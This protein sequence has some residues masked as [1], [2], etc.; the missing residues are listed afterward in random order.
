MPKAIN[1]F[2][3]AYQTHPGRAEPLHSL[4][5][6]YRESNKPELASL[7]YSQAIS[8][9]HPPPNGLFVESNIYKYLLHY[10]FYIFYYYL[11]SNDQSNYSP[12]TIHYILIHLLNA[13]HSGIE[14]IL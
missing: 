4:I 9:P 8:I 14:N 12:D 13:K 1:C 3:E 11:N 5:L 2:L 10:E 6:I 7:F